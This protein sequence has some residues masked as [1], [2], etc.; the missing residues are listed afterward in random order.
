MRSL[1]SD[2]SPSL[3]WLLKLQFQQNRKSNCLCML[4][5]SY[6]LQ[7]LIDLIKGFR[8][9]DFMTDPMIEIYSELFRT[10]TLT[11]VV[12]SH[13]LITHAQPQVELE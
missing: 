7:R 3:Q 8:Q 10:T 2:S 4:F 1:C 12:Y 6:F 13:Y 5:Q 9:F 11:E